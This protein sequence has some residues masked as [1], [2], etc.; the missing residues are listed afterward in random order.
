MKQLEDSVIDFGQAQLGLKYQEVWE[1]HQDWVTWFINKYEK[2]AKENHQRFL[3]FVQLKIER[4]ELEGTNIPLNV[5]PKTPAA[6]SKMKPKAAPRQIYQVPVANMPNM[7]E[8]E[9]FE[10]LPTEEGDVHPSHRD[11]W[12]SSST[13]GDQNAA[14]GR[15]PEPNSGPPG[16]SGSHARGPIDPCPSWAHSLYAGDPEDH[17]DECF[18]EAP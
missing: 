7:D 8:E 3:H 13:L 2:S 5:G 9:L 11:A 15:C 4:A 6:K 18:G 17:V 16:E 1:R 10:L 14:H 12:E